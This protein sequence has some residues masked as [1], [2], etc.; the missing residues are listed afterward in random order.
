MTYLSIPMKGERRN[1]LDGKDLD[2][3]ILILCC[4][5]RD[6]LSG[7]SYSSYTSYRSSG[8]SWIEC[9]KTSIA[10]RIQKKK[11]KKSYFFFF[12]SSSGTGRLSGGMGGGG[13]RG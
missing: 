13:T 9:P 5:S 2:H 1:G 11:E 7:S 4:V 8:H 10:F 12:P 3:S 6:I